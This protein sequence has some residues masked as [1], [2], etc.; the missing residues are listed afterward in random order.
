MVRSSAEVSDG[1]AALAGLEVAV[2]SG[3]TGASAS[4]VA[5]IVTT[6]GT[7]STTFG[8]EATMSDAGV[9]LTAAVELTIEL[10]SEARGEGARAESRT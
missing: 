1:D 6:S 2:S 10:N 9:P 4:L 3:A 8:G 5:A 7:V